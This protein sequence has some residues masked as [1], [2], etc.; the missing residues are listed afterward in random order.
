MI[1]YSQ[2]AYSGL[3]YQVETGLD[4]HSGVVEIG[5]LHWI[6]K[7]QAHQRYCVLG[8]DQLRTLSNI[9]LFGLVFAL[10]EKQRSVRILAA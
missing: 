10:S 5:L 8:C 1:A 9:F 4:P 7:N 3:S 6:S 2:R